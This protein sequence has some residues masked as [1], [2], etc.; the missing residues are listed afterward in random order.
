MSSKRY[1]VDV[2][3][4]RIQIQSKLE[5]YDEMGYDLMEMETITSSSYNSTFTQAVILIF[6][7]REG[8]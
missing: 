2:S 7:M 8:E 1:Q 3:E 5:E 4:L 6:K